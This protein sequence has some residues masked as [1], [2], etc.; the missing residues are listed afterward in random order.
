MD[1]FLL[2]YFFVT[3]STWDLHFLPLCIPV[4]ASVWLYGNAV[5]EEPHLQR[6]GVV[7]GIAVCPSLYKFTDVR[8]LFQ[9][10][11]MFYSLL[12]YLEPGTKSSLGQETKKWSKRPSQMCPQNYNGTWRL[13]FSSRLLFL[14]I[15]ESSGSPL[16]CSQ[17]VL[18]WLQL[19]RRSFS[20]LAALWKTSVLKPRAFSMTSSFS[21]PF[22]FGLPAAG[23]WHR[24]EISLC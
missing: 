10:K 14:E 15:C 9:Y 8:S 24:K 12:P 4:S 3:L 17:S 2:L 19:H 23:F 11:W 6:W 22:W 20:E 13:C 5:A 21:A 18:K 7:S 1:G 16:K